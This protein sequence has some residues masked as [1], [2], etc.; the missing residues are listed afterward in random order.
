MVF[1]FVLMKK[2][3]E[4]AV[5]DNLSTAT[6]VFVVRKAIV[7]RQHLPLRKWEYCVS[8]LSYDTL[9]A[10]GPLPCC[11]IPLW[12]YF[13][14]TDSVCTVSTSAHFNFF[15]FRVCLFSVNWEKL[16]K[17]ISFSWP[18]ILARSRDSLCESLPRALTLI[19]MRAAFPRFL[20]GEWRLPFRYPRL[21]L[22]RQ[23]TCRFWPPY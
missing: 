14:S 11:V 19:S 10:N 18:S 8:L 3:S 23:C 21:L 4:T 5:I 9:H 17:M 12:H 15:F 7:R 1:M 22:R 16:L 20:S 2:C 13:S 6:V